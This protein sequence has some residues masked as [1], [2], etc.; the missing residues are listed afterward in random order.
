MEA[1]AANRAGY[2][3]R[4]AAHLGDAGAHQPPA[5]NRHVLDDDFLRRGRGSGRGGHR[6]HELPGYESHAAET[7][8]A[9]AIRPNEV[10]A[11]QGLAT[12]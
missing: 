10:T 4:P 9:T 11:A 6:A 8:V 2:A 7:K 1:C 3:V 5:D 12:S